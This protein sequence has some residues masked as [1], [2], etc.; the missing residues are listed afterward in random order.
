MLL[1]IHIQ[2][3]IKC[4]MGLKQISCTGLIDHKK[5]KKVYTYTILN[6]DFKL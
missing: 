4:F 5:K 2:C 3:Q 1:K 6:C